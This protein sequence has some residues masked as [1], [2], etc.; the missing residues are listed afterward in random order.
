MQNGPLGTEAHLSARIPR[1]RMEFAGFRAAVAL[2][3]NLRHCG[4]FGAEGGLSSMKE[5]DACVLAT[6]PAAGLAQR[7]WYIH[8]PGVGPAAL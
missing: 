2:L 8:C 5:L 1:E 3:G 4:T 6:L 7:E